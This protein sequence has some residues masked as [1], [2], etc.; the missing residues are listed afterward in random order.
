VLRTGDFRLIKKKAYHQTSC[1]GNTPLVLHEIESPGDKN[2]L[3]RIEDRYQREGRDY[4]HKSKF[5]ERDELTHLVLDERDKTV[6]HLKKQKEQR[7]RENALPIRVTTHRGIIRELYSG[8]EVRCRYRDRN[9]RVVDAYEVFVPSLK[10]IKQA[11]QC[12]QDEYDRILI[13]YDEAVKQRSRGRLRGN[14][15]AVRKNLY[16]EITVVL[17]GT[18]TFLHIEPN[19][20]TQLMPGS[21]DHPLHEL[22]SVLEAGRRCP[23]NLVTRNLHAGDIVISPSGCVTGVFNGRDAHYVT[24]C[25]HSTES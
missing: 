24:Y 21:D 20:G 1:I 22:S 15:I 25:D 11:A 9:G 2:D 18:M 5:I 4:L 10:S 3:V 12:L 14:S 8:T 19:A 17:A 7:T 13:R 16:N 6:E 23:W